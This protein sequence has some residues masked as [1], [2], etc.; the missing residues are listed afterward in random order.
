MSRYYTAIAALLAAA[1]VDGKANFNQ[2][3]GQGGENPSISQLLWQV[4]IDGRATGVP[5]GETTTFYGR[6]EG[7]IET[8]CINGGG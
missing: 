1:G 2:Y 8:K 4:T 6:V 5:N 3:D 7:D